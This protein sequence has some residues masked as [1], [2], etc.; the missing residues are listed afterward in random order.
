[1][2]API[3]DHSQNTPN[4]NPSF[5]N[6][7]DKWFIENPIDFSSVFSRNTEG[8]HS[9]FLSTPLF[10][11]SDHEDANK[12]IDFLYC[13]CRDLFTPVYDHDDDSIA[14]D[15]SNPPIY[16]DLSVDEVKTS[17]TVEAP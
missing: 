2:D 1:M 14:V 12:I 13:S 15:F 8:E 4:V 17:Q 11:L 5:D 3:I 10:D 16:D 6:R 9:C 7:E